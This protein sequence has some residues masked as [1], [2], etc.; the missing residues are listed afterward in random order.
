MS[1]R[2]TT[3]FTWDESGEPA[4]IVYRHA[5]G[6]PEGH[7]VELQEFFDAVETQ[8]NDTRFNDPSYLA[9]KL[10]VWLADKF[11]TR[12]EWDGPNMREVKTEKLDFISVGVVMKDPGDIEYRYVVDCSL[13]NGATRPTVTAYEV[14][15]EGESRRVDI[16]IKEET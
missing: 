13:K 1:T 6:Y 2:C 4:A 5:D 14:Y 7:G 10:V 16:E 8:T 15:G 11:A 9:A 12:F 3:H